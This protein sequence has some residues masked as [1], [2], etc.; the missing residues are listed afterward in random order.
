MNRAEPRRSAVRRV[1]EYPLSVER[2]IEVIRAID[3]TVDRAGVLRILCAA[4]AEVARDHACRSMRLVKGDLGVRGS[5]RFLLTDFGKVRSFSR[6]TYVLAL[7]LLPPSLRLDRRLGSFLATS[8]RAVAKELAHGL[9]GVAT[10]GWDAL[11]PAQYNLIMILKRLADC[12]RDLDYS[13]IDFKSPCAIDKLGRAESFFLMLRYDPQGLEAV[14]AGLD[15]YFRRQATPHEERVRMNGLVLQ[16]LTDDCMVPS[17]YNCIVGLNM[18]KYRRYLTLRGLMREGLGEV[19]DTERYDFDPAIRQRLDRRINDTLETVKLLH[20]QLKEAKLTGSFLSVGTDGE[21]E[22][23]G[24][25]SVYESSAPREWANFTADQENVVLFVYRLLRS[26][27]QAFS[28]L[29]NGQCA[30]TGHGRVELFAP[31]FFALDFTKLRALSETLSQQANKYARFPV[32][33]Y[34]QI[35][36]GRL[37]AI[38]NE[39]E[40]CRHIRQSVAC[41]AD[42]GRMIMK[43]VQLRATPAVPTHGPL[44]PV[45]LHGKPFSIPFEEERIAAGPPLRGLTVLEALRL[46]VTVCLSAGALLR[47]DFVSMH[48]A[49]G[50]R[51]E[52]DLHKSLK[53]L[54][55][56]LDRASF[57]ELAAAYG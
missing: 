55:G 21:P 41:L 57:Q 18:L 28:P 46:A 19:V 56:V 2:K 40:V 8:L 49:R 26:F 53:P 16:L 47:D 45:I 36:E 29:L 42:L 35:K 15:A 30:I 20:S 5:F 34:V 25:K 11:T 13:Q 32:S 7:R 31:S 24:L 17:L 51:L 33:R 44:S 54:Q 43:V 3:Q 6:R 37:Q 50:K 9:M 12:L 22:L 10:D 38:G 27:D 1:L 52:S 23:A 39:E 48:L 14:F 4:A